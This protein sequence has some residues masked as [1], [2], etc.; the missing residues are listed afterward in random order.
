VGPDGAEVRVRPG[1]MGARFVAV[2]PA[3]DAPQGTTSP[4]H[5]AAAAPP[6]EVSARTPGPMPWGDALG[7]ERAGQDG[8]P[9][10]PGG[11][12]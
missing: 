12:A 6:A 4:A 2:F 3:T 7:A 9:R 1:G 10:G 5:R 11:R 8:A